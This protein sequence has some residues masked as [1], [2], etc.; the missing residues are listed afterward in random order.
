MFG[1]H[2]EDLSDELIDLVTEMNKS[3]VAL[4]KQMRIIEILAAEL[5]DCLGES[6]TKFEMEPDRVI[7]PDGTI[8]KKNT[9]STRSKRT[10]KVLPA[11]SKHGL[12]GVILAQ[13]GHAKKKTVQNTADAG[14]T[15]TAST[16]TCQSGVI[17]ERADA[18]TPVPSAAPKAKQVRRGTCLFICHIFYL[19]LLI[20]YSI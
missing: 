5:A 7:W 6:G 10:K 13:Y 8:T 19:S 9:P 17:V 4:W 16:S 20:S 14:S 2:S 15:S 12:Y 3:K 11:V 18:E 1:I